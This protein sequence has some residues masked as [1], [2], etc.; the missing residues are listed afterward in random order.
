LIKSDDLAINCENFDI[1]RCAYLATGVARWLATVLADHAVLRDLRKA[2]LLRG[3][4]HF[5]KIC[6]EAKFELPQTEAS[7]Q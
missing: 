3:Q 1:Q 6:K 5:D 2:T 4:Q 7:H